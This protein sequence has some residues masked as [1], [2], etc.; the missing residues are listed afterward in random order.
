[1]GSS[2]D[3]MI[4][5]LQAQLATPPQPSLFGI[6]APPP[7]ANLQALLGKLKQQQYLEQQSQP[8]GGQYGWLH[9]IAT[10]KQGAAT[11]G[12]YLG[13]AITGGLTQAPQG[14]SPAPDATTSPQAA[15]SGAIQ[16]AAKAYQTLVSKGVPENQAR[17][18][19]SQMLV[20]AGVPGAADV[21]QKAI[22]TGLD[23]TFK[24]AETAKDISQGKM[25]EA[26]I[27][28]KQREADQ[29]T[30]ATIK[31]TPEYMIQRNK[32]GEVRSVK[33]SDKA[34]LPQT[35]EESAQADAIAAK[36]AG[37][38]MHLSSAVGRGNVQ[39]RQDMLGRVLKINPDYDEKNQ[40]QSEDALKAYGPSGTQ[41][42]MIL[43]TQNAM[44][45]LTALDAW[46]T[47]LKTG[48]TVA[49]NKAQ[50]YLQSE[51]NSDGPQ[52]AN[53]ST[54]Q[55]AAPIVANE[56]SSGL[57]KGGG[58][59]DERLDRVATLSG[60]KGDAAFSGASSAMRS[61]L[62]AQYK[63]NKNLYETTT[64][65]KD[66]EKRFPVEG[67]FPAPPPSGTAVAAA[68]TSGWGP[69]QVSK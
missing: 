2:T 43:K 63:N 14:A 58:S 46:H 54:F 64:F 13:N 3:D 19:A 26:S 44:N 29:N 15:M 8:T 30:W 11:I 60:A 18:M 61:L 10:G 59:K 47:A 22:G 34:S 16:Q 51:F 37:Y 1:M 12:N 38:D 49:A 50:Q 21:L 23:E 31:T 36:I 6:S 69:V 42:Q 5:Q 65:R 45:H 52:G 35:P 28:Q 57:V 27:T 32:L 62:G 39:Q 56:V 9:D 66:F 67:G 7:Q 24:G 33:I 20:Q 41:G 68:P 48:N 40:K 17:Q 4:N 55:A 53:L 25:D